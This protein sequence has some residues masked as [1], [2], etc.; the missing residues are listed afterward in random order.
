[1]TVKKIRDRRV[2]GAVPGWVLCKKMGIARSRLSDIERGAIVP[3]PEE[4]QRLDEALSELVEAR[5]QVAQVA[6]RVGWPAP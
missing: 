1:M 6:A 5:R 3:R 4:I 2:K